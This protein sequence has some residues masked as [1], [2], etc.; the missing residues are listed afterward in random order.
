VKDTWKARALS[1]ILKLERELWKSAREPDIDE[2]SADTAKESARL[3]HG[4]R[5]ELKELP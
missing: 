2:K 1:H 3:L 4:L 5:K